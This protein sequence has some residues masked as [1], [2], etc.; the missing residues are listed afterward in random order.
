MAV[1]LAQ[2]IARDGEGATKFIEIQ[3]EGGATQEESLSVA[4]SIANSPLIKTAFF[5]SDP[6]LGR[7]LMAI[8]NA[9]IARLDVSRVNVW[10]GDVLVVE[11]G[12][13]AAT[14]REED[15]ARIMKPEEITVRVD[16][17]RGIVRS[18]VWTCD[19]SYDYV[20]INAEYR[21]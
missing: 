4:R 3:V 11:R 10:L 17:G 8:G 14:Y 5:A 18:V 16:L 21:T 2:S 7:L 9:G 15:G 19:F 1:R 6:N 20:K 13:R 12:G